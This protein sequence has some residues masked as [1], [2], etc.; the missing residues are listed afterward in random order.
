LR[1]APGFSRSALLT[2]FDLGRD[3]AHLVHTSGV[4]LVNYLGY[5]GESEIVI[6]LYERNLFRARLEDIF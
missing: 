3:E 4:N 1:D 5:V 6:T 2:G